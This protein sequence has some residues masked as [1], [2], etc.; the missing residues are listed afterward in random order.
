M[1]QPALLM[2]IGNV[3]LRVDLARME[4]T[5]ASQAEKGGSPGEKGFGVE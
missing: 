1:A 2:D 3:L 5:L 4:T